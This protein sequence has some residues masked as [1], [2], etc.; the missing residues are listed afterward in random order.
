MAQAG[1]VSK[2]MLAR[3]SHIRQAAKEAAI[4]AL[5]RTRVADF[6]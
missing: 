2:S 5:E 1:H 4:M 3:Y 6:K